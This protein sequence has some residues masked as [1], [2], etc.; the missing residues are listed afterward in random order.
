MLRREGRGP[1]SLTNLAAAAVDAQ[2]FAE[3]LATC[4]EEMCADVDLYVTNAHL[5][6]QQS[7]YKILQK[8]LQL[9]HAGTRPNLTYAYGRLGEAFL[10]TLAET[11]RKLMARCHNYDNLCGFVRVQLVG[12]WP[13][14]EQ[15]LEMEAFMI[16]WL[17]MTSE[18]MLMLNELSK[19]PFML[20]DFLGPDYSTMMCHYST[21]AEAARHCVTPYTERF[22]AMIGHHDSLPEN[23]LSEQRDRWQSQYSARSFQMMYVQDGDEDANPNLEYRFQGLCFKHCDDQTSGVRLTYL[24]RFMY[25]E[26]LTEML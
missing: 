19:M 18:D 8:L 4:D 24:I 3:Q 17:D 13:E 1:R 11:N 10:T 5:S 7:F 25:S 20:W 26:Y 6:A 23:Y 2:A 21:P 22:L 9:P 15:S 16:P 14:E 12:Y